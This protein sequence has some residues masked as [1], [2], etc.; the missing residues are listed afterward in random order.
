MKYAIIEN[1]EFARLNLKR[2]IDSLRPDYECSFMAES[3]E[4]CVSYFSRP[5]EVGLIFMDIELDD[6]NCFEIFRRIDL[7]VPVIFT[8]AYD[9]YALKAFKVNSI[10]YLLK[11]I[12]TEDVAL[13]LDKFA[14]RSPAVPDYAALP[15]AF[16][17]RNNG[18]VLITTR[19]GYYFVK[20][21][22]VAWIEAAHKCITL[23]LKDGTSKVTD[24][25]S[26]SEAMAVFDASRFHPLSRSV[27]AAIDSISQVSRHFKGRLRIELN[28]GQTKREEIMTAARKKDFLDWLGFSGNR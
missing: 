13:A 1:E 8:T 16:N 24:F 11:P 27:I 6:G 2:I 14:L 9:E 4:A 25:V 10:D 26:L 19:M 3:I 22:D 20:A 12:L 21:E 23:V 7:K 18:R 5:N 28:A 17:S 15:A